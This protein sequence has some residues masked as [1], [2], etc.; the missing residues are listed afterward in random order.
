[1]EIRVGVLGM[2]D[3]GN[4][5]TEKYDEILDMVALDRGICGLIGDCFFVWLHYPVTTVFYLYCI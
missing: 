5:E 4:W 3:V 2:R 1:M